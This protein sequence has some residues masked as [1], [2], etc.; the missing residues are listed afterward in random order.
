MKRKPL[1]RLAPMLFI[2]YIYLGTSVAGTIRIGNTLGYGDVNRDT[3]AFYLSRLGALQSS[4]Y[5][6]SRL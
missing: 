6:S 3:L 2:P 4:H 5:K 1:L